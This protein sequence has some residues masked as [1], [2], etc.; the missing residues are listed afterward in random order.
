[1]NLIKASIER[2]QENI[3]LLQEK[4]SKIQEY[5]PEIIVWT[6]LRAHLTES[7]NAI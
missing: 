7:L 2:T 1:M 4:L 5:E 3:N 6:L